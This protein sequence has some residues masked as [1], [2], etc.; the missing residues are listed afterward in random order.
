VTCWWWVKSPKG[1]P[2]QRRREFRCEFYLPRGVAGG[3]WR[4]GGGLGA[5]AAV[6]ITTAWGAT[7]ET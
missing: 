6:A 4:G 2:H 5:V 7:A 3:W 1:G